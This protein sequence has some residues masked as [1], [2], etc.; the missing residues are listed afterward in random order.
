MSDEPFLSV[1]CGLLQHAIYAQY[2]DKHGNVLSRVVTDN[3]IKAV[4][5]YMVDDMKDSSSVGY[6]WKRADGKTVKLVCIV[7]DNHD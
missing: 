4:R 2:D 5:D 1:S 3:A 7:E 6:S